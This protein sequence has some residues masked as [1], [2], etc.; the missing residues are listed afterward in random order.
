TEAMAAN[1]APRRQHER[2][3][4][5]ISERR[6]LDAEHRD[7]IDGRE[8]DDR[9]ADH[10]LREPFAPDAIDG[11]TVLGEVLEQMNA[12]HREEV[13]EEGD[14]QPAGARVPAPR[15]CRHRADDRISRKREEREY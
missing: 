5:Q 15:M 14:E 9:K 6:L 3:D 13:D 4:R 12:E 1:R 7:E 2:D 8:I 10:Q 11:V